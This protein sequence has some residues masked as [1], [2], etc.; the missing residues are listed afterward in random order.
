MWSL[1]KI[2]LTD[3]SRL[4]IDDVQKAWDMIESE[5]DA[6]RRYDE[7]RKAKGGG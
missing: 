1:D 6:K 7:I 3:F 5:A 2:S 4:S